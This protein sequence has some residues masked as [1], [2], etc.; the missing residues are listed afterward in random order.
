MFI[1]IKNIIES[2]YF[3][4]MKVVAGARGLGR[5]IKRVSVGDVKIHDNEDLFLEGDLILSCLDQF[6]SCENNKDI[7]EYFDVIIGKK[8]CGIL[9]V[10]NEQLLTQDIKER[11]SANN[12]P[13][14]L[15]DE[16]LSH[17]DITAIINR[18]ILVEDLN[19]LRRFG[20][21]RLMYNV[22]TE[23]EVLEILDSFSTEIKN[24]VKV[25]CFEGKSR[26]NMMNVDIHIKTLN[27]PSDILMEMNNLNYYVVSAEDVSRLNRH[28]D[29]IK[30]VLTQYYEVQHI[31]T[32]KYYYKSEIKEALLEAQN[33]C[34]IAKQLNVKEIEFNPLSSYQMLLVLES[35]NT[36][37]KFYD[38]YVNVIL[39]NTSAEHVNDFME[40]IE[41]FV[42]SGGNFKKTAERIKQ[43][44]N[45]VRYR[46]NKMRSWMEMEED[47]IEFN[48]TISLAVK[49]G[50][51]L[52]NKR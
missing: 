11:C 37:R 8:C 20:L 10:D 35:S 14:L 18:Y 22:L 28:T 51:I 25:V 4:N 48:E 49:L 21:N 16:T 2:P 5:T 34:K 50:N 15:L 38:A 43:H 6:L 27:N 13:V 42:N 39:N 52:K 46:I 23:R 29:Y 26:S 7:N 1:T 24:I 3:N 44:E 32:G 40:T 33:A 31:G 47:V 36:A 17:T 9:V 45:T 12:F 41:C 30:S 19:F